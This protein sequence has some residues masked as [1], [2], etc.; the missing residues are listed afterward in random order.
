M[1]AGMS[2]AASASSQ[3]I[4]TL[5]ESVWSE[6]P[7]LSLRSLVP[8]EARRRTMLEYSGIFDTFAGVCSHSVRAKLWPNLWP[9]GHAPA[10]GRRSRRPFGP[11]VIFGV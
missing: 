7:H 8:N 4:P 9:E 11:L 3:A 10:T 5:S 1:T 6:W 2:P